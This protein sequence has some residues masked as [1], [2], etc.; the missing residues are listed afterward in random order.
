ME[1]K[2]KF[3]ILISLV[4]VIGILFLVSSQLGTNPSNSSLENNDV[5]NTSVERGYGTI[6]ALG[7]PIMGSLDAPVTIMV[8]VDY[9]CPGCRDWFLNIKPNITKNFIETGKANM[10]FVDAKLVGDDSFK[11]A[12]ATY[13]ANE[14]GKYWE[15][16]ELL[17]T[18]QQG[19]NDGWAN[20]ESLKVFAFDLELDM[21]LFENCLDSGK[22][23][24]KV[25]F[26]A[27]EAKKNGLVKIPSFVLVNS[28]GG[29]H[30]IKGVATYSVFE[31]VIEF[32][33]K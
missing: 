2:R 14:Q 12:Q 9:Q 24:K 13:C 31:Q 6:N 30:I 23:D 7:L 18:S 27:Y 21:D 25:R 4:V 22:Y 8:F 28:E 10:V 29:H 33:T 16:Q 15:Y 26:N 5:I 20:P 3:N 17:F 19:I 11:A 1:K 32:L